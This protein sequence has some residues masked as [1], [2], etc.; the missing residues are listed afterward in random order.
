MEA[1][2]VEIASRMLKRRSTNED[3]GTVTISAGVAQRHAG[4]NRAL[5]DGAS[6]YGAL[7]L[8]AG[9]AGTSIS[10]AKVQKAVAA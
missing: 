3:L 1:I 4:R 5:L 2:R 6:G 8:E 9:R 7:H 10:E